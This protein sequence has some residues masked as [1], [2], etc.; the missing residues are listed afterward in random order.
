M[1]MLAEILT[2]SIFMAYTTICMILIYSITKRL[3]KAFPKRMVWIISSA[4]VVFAI[5]TFVMWV[6]VNAYNY[7]YIHM[8]KV[9]RL[10]LGM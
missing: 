9:A 10:M 7:V 3:T 2:I 1:C 8:E 6:S 4:Y 5:A